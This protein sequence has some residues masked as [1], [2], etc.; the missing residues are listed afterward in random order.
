MS[1]EHSS[2][3]RDDVLIALAARQV[4]VASDQ[5]RRDGVIPR[6]P[7]AAIDE[8]AA[9]SA[10]VLASNSI[11]GYEIVAERSRGG[12]GVVYEALQIATRRRVAIKVLHDQPGDSARARFEREVQV[13]AQLRHPNIVTIFDSSRDAGRCFYAMDFV[14]GLPLDRWLA[15]RAAAGQQWSMRDT[16]RLFARIC[17]ALQSAHVRGVIHRD[18]KPNNVLVDAAGE[19]RIVDF[20]LAKITGDNSAAA[21]MT[22]T[23]QFVGSLP[24]SS[25][26]QLAGSA[27]HVDTRSDVFALGVMLF[28][29]LTGRFPYPL[30]VP[31]AEAVQNIRS[32]DVPPPSQSAPSIP[33]DV[34]TLVLKC[35]DKDPDRR[36]QTAGELGRDIE[37]FLQGQPLE[38]RRD[39]IAY[40]L[41]KYAQKYRWPIVVGAAFAALV[42]ASAIATTV[43]WRQASTDRD[44]AREQRERADNRFKQLRRLAHTFIYDLDPRIS[45]L[46]GSTPARLFV[47]QTAKEYLDAIASDPDAD[48]DLVVE[49]AVAYRK[50]GEVLG[51]PMHASL[52][53]FDDA[54][55]TLDQ[56]RAM[57]VRLLDQNPDDLSARRELRATELPI[58]EVLRAQ[59]RM[60]EAT[61]HYQ[62]YL[63]LA[64]EVADQ[65]GVPAD[66]REVAIAQVT[67]SDLAAAQGS[68]TDA[69]ELAQG[70]GALIESLPS[71]ADYPQDLARDRSVVYTRV[72]DRYFDREEYEHA[73]QWYLKSLANDES[74]AAAAPDSATT[75][76]DLTVDLLRVS[77]TLVHDARPQEAAQLV[78]RAVDLRVATLEADPA[79]AQATRDL[80]TAYYV[81]GQVERGVAEAAKSDTAGRIAAL[82]RARDA[83]QRSLDLWQDMLDRGVLRAS[84]RDAGDELRAA[85]AEIET[86]L[87]DLAAPPPTGSDEPR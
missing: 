56:G 86:D 76:R 29:S 87:A 60:D 65:T 10:A 11:A 74:R 20:G 81:L 27:D 58:A 5:A 59:D 16:L 73:R 50:I 4:R 39:S 80:S 9:D 23:G 72:G 38:A 8:G 17:D 79:N 2:S 21:Q 12:Q 41:R 1:P 44:V 57:L 45:D 42:V 48:H 37:R 66:R 83:F 52:G 69:I 43:L 49:T 36:Y 67:M 46:P 15:A 75:R 82:S 22:M 51:R 62:R 24:W 53:R 7:T 61:A 32:R 25:P 28:Q 63:D 3:E 34:D 85:I 71:D 77:E 64:T 18:L 30:D 47:T 13:L 54:L 26:E 78:R 6:G 70:A 68:L 84:D 35:L 33:S 19:P 55:E 31:V 40:V 14:D